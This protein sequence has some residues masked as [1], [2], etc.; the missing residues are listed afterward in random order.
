MLTST[1]LVLLLAAGCNGSGTA[2][3]SAGD[4]QTQ[5][6]LETVC[7]ESAEVLGYSP[8]VHLIDSD[9]A[10]TDVTINST[11][12]DQ[13]RVG[14][15]LAPVSDDSRLPTLFV[16]VQFF[17]LHYDLLVTAFPDLFSGLSTTDYNKLIL[18][19]DSR[20]FYAG[21]LSVYLSS[22]GGGPYYGFTV[23]DDPADSSTTVNQADVTTAWEY[24]QP[25]FE[26]GELKFVPGTS[27]QITASSSWR[28]TPF[29]IAGQSDVAYEAYNPGEGYGTLRLYTLDELAAASEIAE[30]GYQDIVVISE[31]P[32]DLERVVSGI[33]T[34]TR[35]GDLSHL[36]VLSANRGTPNCFIEEPLEALADWQDQLVRFECGET[37]YSV[38][39]TTLAQAEAW[40]ES[41]RPDPVE[42]CEPDLSV[43]NFP[44]LLALDTSSA[45]IRTAGVCG[46][47]SKGTN[48][49]T[50]YQRIDNAYAFTGFLIPVYY[51]D[52]FVRD[53]TWNVDLGSG[54]AEYSF[55]DTL[56]AWHADEDFVGDAATRREWLE[57]LRYAMLAAPVDPDLVTALGERIV[58]VWGTDDTMVRFRSSSN[59]EDSLEFNGAGLYESESVCLADETDNDNVGPCLCDP[60][61]SNEKTVSDG[62]RE[63][64]SSLWNMGAWEERDWYGIDQGKV[65]MGILVNDRSKDEEANIVAFTG[66]PTSD[67]DDR[68]LINAQEGELEV[69][70]AEAG[71]FPE[72]ILLTLVGG[73]VTEIFR[74][75]PS[76]EV[77]EVLTDAELTELGEVLHDVREVYPVDLDIPEDRDLLWDTEWKVTS[78]GRL[79][80]KQ[81]RPYIR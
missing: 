41:I 36:N 2:A 14:K 20:E 13:L 81:I 27:N 55:Q 45:E 67:G 28:D 71:V 51:Y 40:W 54:T 48:L 33:V 61:K 59:A 50:L 73:S 46:Y 1:A 80:I 72:S 10:F 75:S 11:A 25:R 69:V 16:N 24:L 43:S 65:A 57:D 37:D 15:Y 18:Y 4:P 70:A 22:D 52:A 78:E 44:G 3:D 17:S 30:F 12:V 34:G 38:E 74:V 49:A 62:L 29:S 76:S 31:A 47:G 66:N 64:W 53:S 5:L 79:V 6:P 77:D 8:C 68:F 26:V 9:Q 63:V 7:L 35:Q 21:T 32:Q 19:P 23:W 42:I 56:D 60:D 58:Q 39:A